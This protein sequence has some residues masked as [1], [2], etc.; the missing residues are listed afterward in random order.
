MPKAISQGIGTLAFE[1]DKSGRKTALDN[2]RCAFGE[3]YDDVRMH[4][5]AKG[6][7]QTFARTFL[8][9]F[10]SAKH[11]KYNWQAFF[12]IHLSQLQIEFRER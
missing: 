9:L 6:L 8:D 11:T 7:Y 5:I 2:L 10:W 1:I 3:Q 12:D 4:R